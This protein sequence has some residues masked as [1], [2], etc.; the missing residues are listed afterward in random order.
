MINFLSLCVISCENDL[1]FSQNLDKTQK[2]GN[3]ALSIGRRVK[4]QSHFSFAWVTLGAWW[5][6]DVLLSIWNCVHRNFESIDLILVC[7]NFVSEIVFLCCFF[8]V[9]FT[10]DNFVSAWAIRKMCADNKKNFMIY[11]DTTV[12]KIGNKLDLLHWQ[13][14]CL[15]H[16]W[17]MLYRVS[18]YIWFCKSQRTKTKTLHRAI[19]SIPWILLDNRILWTTIGI[20]EWKSP[21]IVPFGMRSSTSSTK[22]IFGI[23]VPWRQSYSRS[24]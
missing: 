3:N 7:N 24:T 1:N 14:R 17:M 11:S 16:F 2:H 21:Q 15:F 5:I 4:W 10:F 19:Q 13:C 18:V 20:D 12:I 23:L 9:H 8:V 22:C 6:I